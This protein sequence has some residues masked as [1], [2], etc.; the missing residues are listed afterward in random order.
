MNKKP[1]LSKLTNGELVESAFRQIEKETNLHIVDV[2][3][4]DCY[5]IIEGEE[6]S[7]CHF[8]IKEIPGFKF[9]FW[10][11]KRFDKIKDQMKENRTTWAETYKV[12][13]KTELIFFT[14][15]ER[16]E[17]KFKP[18]HSGFRTG[19]FR[20][21]WIETDDN[22]KNVVVEEWYMSDLLDILEYMKKHPIKSYVYVSAQIEEVWNEKSSLKCLKIYV[23]DWI[24]YYKS[25][26]RYWCKV[27]KHLN[28]C[29]RFIRKTKSFNYMLIE[30]QDASPEVEL[31]LARKNHISISQ[32]QK[33]LDK[34]EKFYNKY[35]W[36]IS[37]DMFFN[38]IDE[39]STSEEIEEDVNLNE[40][41]NEYTKDIINILNGK[42]DDTLEDHW[43]KRIVK[44]NLDKEEVKE[45]AD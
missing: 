30:R 4:E 3:F 18:S 28:V 16:D 34:L 9:A 23:M 12:Y 14:Q 21:A 41:F 45:Y 7:I 10:N 8:H 20:Q 26:F 36:K 40:R 32:F 33:D 24:R 31:R 5:F 29:K 37:I 11:T 22:N 38:E 15:Y 27:H 35:Y 43:I 25:K 39:N 13:N 44:I 1:K 6:D 2:E 17:D 42:S 19:I